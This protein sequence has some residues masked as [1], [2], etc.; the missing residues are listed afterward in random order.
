MSCARQARVRVV[1]NEY[2]PVT[3]VLAPVPMR[4]PFARWMASPLSDFVVLG[5][6]G[7]AASLDGEVPNSR[8]M[9]LSLTSSRVTGP[10]CAKDRRLPSR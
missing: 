10:G 8:V 7:E 9:P 5:S 6:N 4:A 2:M 3:G 1:Y